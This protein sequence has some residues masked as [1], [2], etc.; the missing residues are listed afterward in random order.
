M[1]FAKELRLLAALIFCVLLLDVDARVLRRDES[2]VAPK[3]TASVASSKTLP[4]FTLMTNRPAAINSDVRILEDATI[5]ENP[6]D[7][8]S[9]SIS[10]Q[11]TA[12]AKTTSVSSIAA[13]LS[14]TIS[15]NVEPSNTSALKSEATE[16]EYWS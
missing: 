4:A 11:V 13:S 5:S 3:K 14:P 12:V 10:S 1:F 15:D 9:T 2:S 16:C 6:I 8:S 7:T